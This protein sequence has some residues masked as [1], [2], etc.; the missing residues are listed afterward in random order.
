MVPLIQT[1]FMSNNQ[2]N[3]FNHYLKVLNSYYY[4]EHVPPFKKF[5]E[6][7][8]KKG[9]E[10]IVS[11]TTAN[12]NKWLTLIE[13]L[14]RHPNIRS[15]RDMDVQEGPCYKAVLNIRVN[16]DIE[17]HVGIIVFLSFLGHYIGYYFSDSNGLSASL[18]PIQ[19]GSITIRDCSYSPI[20]SEQEEILPEIIDVIKKEFPAFSVF[21][22]EFADYKVPQIQMDSVFF[23]KNIDLFQAFFGINI[24]GVI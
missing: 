24:H 12:Y 7:Y 17:R 14:R 21:N 20:I 19:T 3:D 8:Y 6:D 22:N 13:S 15:V 11:E 2:S 9:F 4:T 23:R 5:P 18:K 10:A 16:D 1:L